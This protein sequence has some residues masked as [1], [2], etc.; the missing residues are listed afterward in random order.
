MDTTNLSFEVINK[1]N[2]VEEQ[3]P[4]YLFLAGETLRGPVFDPSI[5]IVSWVQ[6]VRIFGGFV[7]GNHFPLICNRLLAR[8]AKLR[9]SRVTDGA[10]DTAE[11]ASYI[12]NSDSDDLFT[13]TAKYPGADYNNINIVI[14]AGSN[15][16]TGYFDIEITHDTDESVYEVYTNLK[17]DDATDDDYLYDILKKSD[18][19]IPVYE[20]LTGVTD[21]VPVN[22]TY[23]LASGSDGGTVDA[24]DYGGVA[25]TK[26]GWYAFDDFS[27][28]YALAAPA[29][30]QSDL[31]IASGGE[32]YARNRGDIRYYQHIDITNTTAA[33]IILE[34]DGALLDSKYI[35]WFSGGIIVLDPLTSE[36]INIPELGDVL[37]CL[38]DTFKKYKPWYSF[39]GPN[40]GIIPNA[41]GVVNNFGSSANYASLNLLANNQV[42]MVVVRD[43]RI[44]L[45]D[46]FSGQTRNNPEKFIS[47][48][49]LILYLQKNLGPALEYF[50]KE[51]NDIPTWQEMY[52][53][54]KPFLDS[55]VDDRGI[56]GY[57]WNG[58]QNASDLDSLQ[59]NK[60]DDVIDGEYIVELELTPIPP[61]TKFKVKIIITRTSV[62]FES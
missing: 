52:Y 57:T 45:W 5:V 35:N 38:I 10:E 30:S 24:A 43:N 48:N 41:L 2:G 37:G 32:A 29:I 61:L 55:V 17:I 8:G 13:F 56:Y 47:V 59:V 58:D 60:K 3:S 46:D 22:G 20:D 9:I 51:P 49:N 62:T 23:S 44:M 25:G 4:D 33:N 34:K 42:N 21:F 31:A 36:K 28:A 27:E 19:V 7:S 54:V 53:T 26:K 18:Y 14:S 12:K 16:Q 11:L 1:A 50:L 15:A 6:F 40:R 39:A